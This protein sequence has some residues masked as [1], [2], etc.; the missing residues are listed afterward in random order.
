LGLLLVASIY[1]APQPARAQQQASDELSFA[2]GTRF[3][4]L[5]PVQGTGVVQANAS[6]SPGVEAEAFL[7]SPTQKTPISS[8]QGRGALALSYPVTSPSSGE[9][10]LEIIVRTDDPNVSGTVQ[11]SWP[12]RSGAQLVWRN[13]GPTDPEVREIIGR[14]SASLAHVLQGGT[15]RNDAERGLQARLT[16]HPEVRADLQRMQTVASARITVLERLAPAR[17]RNDFTFQRRP[18]Q[19]REIRRLQPVQPAQPAQ[20]LQPAQPVQPPPQQRPSLEPGLALSARF[21]LLDCVDEMT[22]D[23]GSNSDEPYV[24]VGFIR[25]SGGEA[26]G[27]R[28]QVFDDVDDGERRP[29]MTMANRELARFYVDSRS[30]FV[31][32]L[33]ENDESR[34]NSILFDFLRSLEHGVDYMEEGWEWYEFLPWLGWIWSAL[35][36]QDDMIGD[37]KAMTITPDGWYDE[38]GSLM[39]YNMSTEH[40]LGPIVVWN[41][42]GDGGNYGVTLRLEPIMVHSIQ[43]FNNQN[44]YVRHRYY[45]GQLTQISSDPD[46]QDATFMLVPGLANDEHISFESVNFRGYFL[47][48]DGGR[49]MLR[50]PTSEMFER[51]GTF[52]RVPGLADGSWSSFESYVYPGRYIRHRDSQ[53]VMQS[54]QGDPFRQDATFLLTGPWW[55]Q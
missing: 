4:F 40:G 35:Q 5:L 43:S 9:W 22:W 14:M 6:W 51:L 46:R 52:K 25:R 27:G 34:P 12:G 3:Q 18:A 19:P 24:L 49:L 31:M 7:F 11:V 32:A 33:M 29:G 48:D 20:P 21:M 55:R 42:R 47:V 39:T 10:M 17:V 28:T 54:G 41:F 37:P 26:V 38:H 36:N 8:S 2:G 1:A 45:Q 30:F 16:E 15:P 50:Q 23:R 13:A 53:L 44:Q